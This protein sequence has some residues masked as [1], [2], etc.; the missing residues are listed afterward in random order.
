MADVSWLSY[1]C[2]AEG[3]LSEKGELRAVRGGLYDRK[4]REE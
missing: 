2:E 3:G 1:D 4:D